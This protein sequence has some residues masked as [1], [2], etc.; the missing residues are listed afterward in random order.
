LERHGPKKRESSLCNDRSLLDR[1]I[2]PRLGAKLV[3]ELSRR[4]VE[5]LHLSLKETPYQ[6]NRAMALLSK[7]LSLAIRWGWRTDNPV[8]GIERFPEERRER[9]LRDNELGRLLEALGRYPDRRV[10]DAI[11]LLMLTGARRSEVFS[12]TW[13]EFDLGR[14]VWTKP[15]HHTKQKR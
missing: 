5:T 14:G 12:A 13:E 7:M 10:A 11:R 1:F 3:A 4:D 6:A 9:W 8:K 2:L 15:S